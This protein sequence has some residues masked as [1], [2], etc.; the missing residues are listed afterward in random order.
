MFLLGG[1][2]QK[3][4]FPD[5]YFVDSTFDYQIIAYKVFF[6]IFVYLIKRR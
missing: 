6:F 2:I 4:T 3:Q 5:V 1:I